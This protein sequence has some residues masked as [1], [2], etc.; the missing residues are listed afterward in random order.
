MVL[1]RLSDLLVRRGLRR[2]LLAGEQTWL[3]L[4]ALALAGR[5]AL[6]VLRRRPE[7]VF[8]EKLEPG[9]HLVITH[10]SRSG[11]NGRR[12]SPVAEPEA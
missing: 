2:G 6:R 11:N 4:G 7:V 1:K 5:L 10:R 12:E 3:V 8:T 9:H